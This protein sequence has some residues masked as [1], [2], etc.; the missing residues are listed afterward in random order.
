MKGGRCLLRS[1]KSRIWPSFSRPHFFHRRLKCL[2]L[3]GFFIIIITKSP[4][5][6]KVFSNYLQ[7]ITRNKMWIKN[8]PGDFWMTTKTEAQKYSKN[9]W[10]HL[11]KNGLLCRVLLWLSTM[12]DGH[13]TYLEHFSFSLTKYH[14]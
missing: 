13:D 7:I 11:Y 8:S 10:F 12:P 9:G 1:H 14:G 5:T 6:T 2:K 4:F 3:L